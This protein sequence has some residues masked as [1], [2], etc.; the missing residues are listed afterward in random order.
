MDAVS[1]VSVWMDKIYMGEKKR[2]DR[3]VGVISVKHSRRS[4]TVTRGMI[5]YRQPNLRFCTL[6]GKS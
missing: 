1:N 4:E 3:G 6:Y 5:S 2:V